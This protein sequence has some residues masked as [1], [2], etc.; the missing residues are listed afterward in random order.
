MRIYLTSVRKANSEIAMHL[1]AVRRRCP[2]DFLSPW[3]KRR[4]RSEQTEQTY[5]D[6]QPAL[7]ISRRSRDGVEHSLYSPLPDL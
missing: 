5:R 6:R 1:N 7:F 3:I 2:Q 4:R